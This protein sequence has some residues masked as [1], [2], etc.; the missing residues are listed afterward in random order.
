MDSNKPGREGKAAT[1]SLMCSKLNCAWEI[2][3]QTQNRTLGGEALIENPAGSSLQLKPGRHGFGIK[4]RMRIKENM[5][6]GWKLLTDR[7]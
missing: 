4:F 2:R 3:I 6:E 5:I 1:V 7:T